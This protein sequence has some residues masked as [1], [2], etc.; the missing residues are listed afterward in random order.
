MVVTLPGAYCKT[1]LRAPCLPVR[2]GVSGR[3]RGVRRPCR[4]PGIPGVFPGNPADAENI[5]YVMDVTK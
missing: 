3:S 5:V 4:D 2:P 1:T